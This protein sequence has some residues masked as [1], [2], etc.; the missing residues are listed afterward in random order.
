MMKPNNQQP[1]KREEELE[2][3]ANAM[4]IMANSLDAFA[5][6]VVDYACA[7]R[8]CS[9]AT[10]AVAIEDGDTDALDLCVRE[11]IKHREELLN[12]IEAFLLLLKETDYKKSTLKE[13]VK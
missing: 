6:K 1:C 2:I 4:F 10:A 7:A 3:A 8:S 13:K 11:C 9:Y 12:S 5:C